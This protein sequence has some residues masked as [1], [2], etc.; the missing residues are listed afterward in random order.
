[1]KVACVIVLVL[2]SVGV[3]GWIRGC[4]HCLG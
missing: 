4:K 2:Y 1:M 3:L